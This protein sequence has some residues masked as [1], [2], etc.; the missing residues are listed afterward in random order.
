MNGPHHH[1]IGLHY[2]PPTQMLPPIPAGQDAPPTR[3]CR[4]C[5]GTGYATIW[6]RNGLPVRRNPCLLCDL[7]LLIRVHAGLRALDNPAF[8]TH[9]HVDPSPPEACAVRPSLIAA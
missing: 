1:P 4:G 6:G 2:A 9:A 3:F 8:D 5:W 7:G